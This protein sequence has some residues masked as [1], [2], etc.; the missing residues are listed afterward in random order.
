MMILYIYNKDISISNYYFH[1]IHH[2]DNGFSNINVIFF[3][4]LYMLFFP[5]SY[6]TFY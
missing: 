1:Y 2:K 6:D 5:I 3:N 4:L